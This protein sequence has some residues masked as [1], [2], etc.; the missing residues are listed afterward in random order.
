M[1][2]EP[3]TSADTPRMASLPPSSADRVPGYNLAPL[4]EE[5]ARAMLQRVFGGERGAALWKDACHVAG[6]G[7]QRIEGAAQ[8]VRV[9]QALATHG[10]APAAVGRSMEIRIRTHAALT[11]RSTTS[12]RST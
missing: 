3:L 1:L 5:D 4:L 9:A 6:F 2:V 11:A 8:L 7:D 12:R 10:G